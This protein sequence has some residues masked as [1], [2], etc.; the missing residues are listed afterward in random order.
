LGTDNTN[1]QNV[2]GPWQSLLPL[3]GHCLSN[4]T[5]EWEKGPSESMGGY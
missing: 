5:G 1:G 3:L 2:G 4:V